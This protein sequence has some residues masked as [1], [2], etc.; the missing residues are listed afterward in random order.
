[1]T[2]IVSELN[3]RLRENPNLPAGRMRPAD[4][5]IALVKRPERSYQIIKEALRSPGR[6]YHGGVHGSPISP[7]MRTTA[8]A[9][10]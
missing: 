7:E 4:R 9:P 8:C 5:L 6:Q 1:M 10:L 3:Q 2:E